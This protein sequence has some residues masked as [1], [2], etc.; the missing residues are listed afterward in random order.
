MKKNTVI[1]SIILSYIVLSTPLNAA[2]QECRIVLKPERSE[3]RA[4]TYELTHGG[5]APFGAGATVSEDVKFVPGWW[6]G[7]PISKE[8]SIQHAKFGG[9][10]TVQTGNDLFLTSTTYKSLYFIGLEDVAFNEGLLKSTGRALPNGVENSMLVSIFV[11]FNG[12]SQNILVPRAWCTASEAE[13]FVRVFMDRI[14]EPFYSTSV[15][16]KV[17]VNGKDEYGD[18][19]LTFQ[20]NHTASQPMDR[21]PYDIVRQIGLNL[22][23]VIDFGSVETGVVAKKDLEVGLIYTGIPGRGYLTFNYADTKKMEVIINEKGDPKEHN[24][25]YAKYLN[26]LPLDSAY[27]SYQIGVKSDTVGGIEQRVRVTF[28]VF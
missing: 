26:G 14:D 5:G 23:S 27:L 18:A 15:R 8:L 11:K 9:S 28:N 22:P 6:H 2:I 19:I 20:D 13:R 12:L 16:Y 10:V 4:F 24:L 1:F 3:F 25:P 21:I 7:N 17:H